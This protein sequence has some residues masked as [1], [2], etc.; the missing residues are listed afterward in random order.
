KLAPSV[1][2]RNRDRW[3]DTKF[4]ERGGGLGAADH[5]F[6]VADRRQKPLPIDMSLCLF[7]QLAGADPG[8]KN[9]DIDLPGDQAVGKIYRASM[10]CEWHFPHRGTYERHA[11][12]L[13]DH[14]RNVSRAATFKCR[15]AQAAKRSG[16]ARH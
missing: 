11:A 7:Y 14:P 10:L 15:D 8:E 4:L 6:Y 16:L 13:F 1:G 5:G 12:F 9:N 2:L 3:R